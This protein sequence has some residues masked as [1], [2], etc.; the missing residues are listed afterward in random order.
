[1]IAR[2]MSAALIAFALAATAAERPPNVLF[3]MA[4]DL[5]W[6]DLGCFGSTFHKTPNLDK[7]AARG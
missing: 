1:M 5:G 7:L 3:I 6:R 2:W 4:D